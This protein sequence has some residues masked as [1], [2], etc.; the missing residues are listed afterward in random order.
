MASP[1]LS[2]RVDPKT[3]DQLDKAS[4]RDG[5]SRSELAKTLIEEGLRMRAHPGIVFRP[6]PTGRRA[7]LARGPD[8]WEVMNTLRTANTRPKKTSPGRRLV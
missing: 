8:V 1:H 2:I 7:A 5:M 6:G 3:L 4:R